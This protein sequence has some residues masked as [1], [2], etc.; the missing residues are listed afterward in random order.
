MKT[1]LVSLLSVLW[2][3]LAGPAHAQVLPKPIRP[4]D[5]SALIDPDNNDGPI[6]I[7][8]F[9]AE[10]QALWRKRDYAMLDSLIDRWAK[11]DERFDDGRMHLTAVSRGVDLAVARA[12]D[13]KDWEQE[14]ARISE[15]RQQNPASTAVDIV[16]AAILQSWAWSARG[17]GYARTVTPEAWKLFNER[18]NRAQEVLFRSKDRSSNNPL[19]FYE[20]MEVALQLGWERAEFRALYDAA[21]ARFPHFHPLY[22]SMIRS[23]EPRWGGSIEEIDAYIAEVVKQAKAREGKIMYA[24]LY[25][26]LAGA[27]GEEFALF[28]DSAA[29][30]ADMKAGFRLLIAATPKSRWN[31]NNFASFA[32]RAGD[33]DTYRKLRKQIGEQVY[34]DA[35]PSNLTMEVCD[36]RLLKVI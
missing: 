31:L 4:G 13:P 30:W 27:E 33:A 7:H 2:L 11:P 14:L 10:V 15:W 9:A 5:G 17:T 6:G 18:M 1:M 26:Y 20:Y 29:N 34:E 28:E 23:L 36:E 32:C 24:R 22:F 35:W 25:W 16:E 12:R 19:W 8:V 21:I 3:G